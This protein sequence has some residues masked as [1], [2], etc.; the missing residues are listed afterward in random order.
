MLQIAQF[1]LSTS[2]S[3]PFLYSPDTL[4]TIIQAKQET[5]SLSSVYLASFVTFWMARPL[6]VFLRDYNN[7]VM[8]SCYITTL[9][10]YANNH[11]V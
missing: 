1:H 4:V 5:R 8:S 9:S 7:Y 2:Y 3:C 10:L 11:G 6:F